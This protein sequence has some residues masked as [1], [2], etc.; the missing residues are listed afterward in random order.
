MQSPGALNYAT[1]SRHVTNPGKKNLLI[2]TN[3]FT[4]FESQ[5]SK[6]VNFKNSDFEV[7]Y[8]AFKSSIIT[9]DIDNIIPEE[10]TGLIKLGIALF[11]SNNGLE[12]PGIYAL[13]SDN[14]IEKQK[15]CKACGEILFRL[16][17]CRV[18]KYNSIFKNQENFHLSVY[19]NAAMA[20]EH[21]DR[22]IKIECLD[23]S[24]KDYP[25]QVRHEINHVLRQIESIKQSHGCDILKCDTKTGLIKQNGLLYTAIYNPV[26]DFGPL[27]DYLAK[28]KHGGES[29]PQMAAEVNTGAEVC[30]G[31]IW[32]L[33]KGASNSIS[34]ASKQAI[35][36][37]KQYILYLVEALYK[38]DGALLP[39]EIKQIEK[40]LNLKRGNT[41]QNFF[42]T[43]FT[44][45]TRSAYVFD[46][47]R[48]PKQA[49]RSQ[50]DNLHIPQTDD[51]QPV[52]ADK[53]N[54][55]EEEKNQISE[56][57]QFNDPVIQP[58]NDIEEKIKDIQPSFKSFTE[59]KDKTKRFMQSK[60]YASLC[61]YIKNLPSE[62]QN[63]IPQAVFKINNFR[64]NLLG[65][66]Q[67][68]EANTEII[69]YASLLNVVTDLSLRDKMVQSLCG[70][71]YIEFYGY[72][73]SYKPSNKYSAL[74]DLSH[75]LLAI[76]TS[77]KLCQSQK[78]SLIDYLS[79]EL[80]KKSKGNFG[81]MRVKRSS[82]HN[83]M[84]L[85]AI[86]YQGLN[87]K[88]DAQA[89]T[90][91]F[92]N[93][94]AIKNGISGAAGGT[95]WALFSLLAP[96]SEYF[97]KG[98]TT[99]YNS[100]TKILYVSDQSLS[101]TMIDNRESQSDQNKQIESATES[102]QEVRNKINEQLLRNNADLSDIID[103]LEG[104]S[105]KVA[106]YVLTEDVGDTFLLD[107]LFHKLTGD[108][109]QP[110][111]IIRL[112]RIWYESLKASKVLNCKQPNL[113]PSQMELKE[114]KQLVAQTSLDTAT[115]ALLAY[116]QVIAIISHDHDENRRIE[117]LEHFAGIIYR[118]KND[119]TSKW[120]NLRKRDAGNELLLRSLVR[121]T[122]ALLW[123]IVGTALTLSGVGLTIL[124]P[125]LLLC[126]GLRGVIYGA[127]KNLTHTNTQ[128]YKTSQQIK[129]LFPGVIITEAIKNE[130]DM[131]HK[132][133]MRCNELMT[134]VNAG[135]AGDFDNNQRLQIGEQKIKI[136]AYLNTVS[137]KFKDD[138]T[139][140][141]QIN[142]IN[143]NNVSPEVSQTVLENLQNIV[144]EISVEAADK[145][146]AN[147]S[148][149]RIIRIIKLSDLSSTAKID[150]ILCLTFLFKERLLYIASHISRER[151][152]TRRRKFFIPDIIFGMTAASTTLSGLGAFPIAAIYQTL[153]GGCGDL[154]GTLSL[155][156]LL[157]DYE[158]N[159]TKTYQESMSFLK[160]SLIDEYFCGMNN[161]GKD[162]VYNKN[163]EKDFSP[164]LQFNEIITDSNFPSNSTIE[165]TQAA[166]D[167]HIPVAIS[168]GAAKL[169][170]QRR[171]IE[172]LL[173]IE[174]GRI[175]SFMHRGPKSQ[176]QFT[177]QL[178]QR[179][180]ELMNPASNSRNSRANLTSE[181]SYEGLP[182]NV[183][184]QLK[185]KPSYEPS[186]Q[187]KNEQGKQLKPEDD[188]IK[189]KQSNIHGVDANIE[190]DNI[191][192]TVIA[193]KGHGDCGL[194]AVADSLKQ[195]YSFSKSYPARR[196]TSPFRGRI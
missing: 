168:N 109:N 142:S 181:G 58:E 179:D 103:K 183:N 57:M 143:G 54:D 21:L 86:A 152:F 77:N 194:F 87:V 174:T 80:H 126:D 145:Y 136:P 130:L 71:D 42:V 135:D 74:M 150:L 65:H 195:G 37:Y 85:G 47:I 43:A 139:Y 62:E 121:I 94:E 156:L 31:I 27:S 51:S 112:N 17:H 22:I 72:L 116:Y 191:G 7:T 98:N 120:Y 149:F 133:V 49:S 8:A 154:V 159:N 78:K 182:S 101:Q 100:L 171:N 2:A 177:E 185:I 79:Y 26:S 63:M 108:N 104:L 10:D 146:L 91:L 32:A 118:V 70:F 131:M 144:T 127:S 64:G 33:S 137:D 162:I 99:T 113:E 147:Q 44:K 83:D 155:S 15:L 151:D 184:R 105:H 107:A 96:I 153:S 167:S 24:A 114:F 3:K 175:K 148:L 35:G 59:I 128:Q 18:D 92:S 29:S 188:K 6:P 170:T 122:G 46:Q 138:N 193:N 90:Q 190:L 36:V 166:Q 16:K 141:D 106:Y 73:K 14:T 1:K 39:S 67:Q 134:I 76:T 158:K 125:L 56:V 102:V 140:I 172:L 25:I 68:Q 165:S 164:P 40:F 173:Q 117:K 61:A 13:M 28:E 160:Y 180:L 41:F 187:T 163:P 4:W 161:T 115:T 19:A 189:N 66:L 11:Y 60:D 9:R 93:S 30:A 111:L 186:M 97:S 81:Q 178:N 20:I 45:R 75:F 88:R 124:I 119:N 132:P 89:I 23:N 157:N 5:Q 50:H 84:V 176:Q 69:H 123:G 34:I 192:G 196:K 52:L 48:T 55:N 53:R 95:G 169:D 129:D 12:L 82:L 38:S 110:S